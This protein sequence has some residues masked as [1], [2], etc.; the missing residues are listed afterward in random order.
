MEPAFFSGDHVLTCNYC[1]ISPGDVIVFKKTNRL[2]IKRVSK[3]KEN[4]IYAHGANNLFSIKKYKIKR[5]EVIGKVIIK[6]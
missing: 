1:N 5:S 3:I 6:Y 4:V 2:F